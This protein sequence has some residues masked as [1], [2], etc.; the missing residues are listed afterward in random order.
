[1]TWRARKAAFLLGR[2]RAVGFHDKGVLCLK[3]FRCPADE[4]SVVCS[5]T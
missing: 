3:R 1:M 5:L 4:G 2:L